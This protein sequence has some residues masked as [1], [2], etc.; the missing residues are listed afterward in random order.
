MSLYKLFK[1]D[2]ASEQ[3]GIWLE[4]A[5]EDGKGPPARIKIA[6]A[7]GSNAKYMRV[8]E[9]RYKP[10]RR[11]SQLGI[12]DPKVSEEILAQVYAEAVLLGWENVTDPEG[13]PLPFNVEN[14]VKLLTD[15]P[16]LFS[17]IQIQANR[18]SLFRA[19]LREAD[20]GNS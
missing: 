5:D 13:K 12:L 16:E 2:E 20:A 15:L 14:A 8:L 7:G 4:Y 17:E 19:D 3:E 10:V 6:R 18:M 9:R 11:Q 1:T